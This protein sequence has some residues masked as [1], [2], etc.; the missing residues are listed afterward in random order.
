[1]RGK[2]EKGGGKGDLHMER[3]GNKEDEKE[4][5]KRS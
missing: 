3:M 5:K 2:R 4:V 1:M